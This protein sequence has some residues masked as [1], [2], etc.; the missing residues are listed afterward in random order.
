MQI[1]GQTCV[2][3]GYLNLAQEVLIFLLIFTFWFILN[4][5]CLSSGTLGLLFNHHCQH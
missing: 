2:K 1:R 5:V 3:M 4:L